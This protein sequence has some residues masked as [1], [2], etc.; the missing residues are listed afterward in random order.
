M[1][2]GRPFTPAD[3][4]AAQAGRHPR[5]LRLARAKLSAAEFKQRP[6]LGGA[7]ER[8]GGD[9]T[10]LQSDG[11]E[12]D[13]S[14]FGAHELAPQLLGVELLEP[15]DPSSVLPA[16][17]ADREGRYELVAVHL[18]PIG[19]VRALARIEASIPGRVYNR[20]LNYLYSR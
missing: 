15:A 9:C 7:A 10:R 8:V 6:Q 18:S 4:R 1:A 20:K 13:P 2:A 16:E 17:A 19:G 14:H 3:L 12:Q 5:A 11:S